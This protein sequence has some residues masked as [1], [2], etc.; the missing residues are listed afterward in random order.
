MKKVV[1]F[2]FLTFVWFVVLF[3]KDILWLGIKGYIYTEKELQIDSKE[4][5]IKLY[6]LYNK[7]ILKKIKIANSFDVES[8]QAVYNVFDAPFMIKVNGKF[9]HGDFIGIVN[10]KSKK[11]FILFK[12]KKSLDKSVFKSYLKKTE[13]GYRY[14]FD[15]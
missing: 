3:P 10:L 8:F 15:I 4:V 9:H 14:E 12:D 5:D 2:F 11:G 7:I 13:D 6:V 1:L